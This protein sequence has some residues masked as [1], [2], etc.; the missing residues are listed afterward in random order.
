MNWEYLDK[1]L[2]EHYLKKGDNHYVY[3]NHIHCMLTDLT[4]EQIDYGIKNN[5][6]TEIL[7]DYKI[8][9]RKEKLNILKNYDK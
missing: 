9:R 6:S 5:E 4:N 2:F 8:K 3:I 1:Q 7:K